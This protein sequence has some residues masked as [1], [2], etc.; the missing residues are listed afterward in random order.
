MRSV[1]KRSSVQMFG[2][3]SV[4]ELAGGAGLGCRIVVLSALVA[5]PV[6]PCMPAPIAGAGGP[7]HPNA[8]TPERLNAAPP[9]VLKSVV[10]NGLRLL[11]KP[12]PSSDIVAI[13]CL[14]RVGVRDEPEENAGIAALLGEAMIRGTERHHPDQM[15][16]AVGAVGGTLEVTPGFDFTEL[17]LATTRDR[18]PQALQLLAEVLGSASLEPAAIDAARTALK[19]RIAELDD[20][21]TASSYQEL[22]LQL[23]PAAP[24]GRPVNGYPASLDRIG[25]QQLDTFY[26]DHYVQNNIVI[27]VVGNIDANAAVEQTRKAFDR[28]EFR[29]QPPIPPI[30]ETF[31]GRPRVSMRQRP[32]PAAQVMLGALAPPTSAASYPTWMVLDAI[33]GGGKRARLFTNLREK[34][35]IG[36][37]LGSFFQPL[38]D[39]SHLVAYVVTAPYRADPRTQAPELALDVVRTQMLEQFQSLADQGPTAAELQRAK[40]YVIGNFARKHERNRDQAHWLVWMEAVGLGFG[41]D[42]DLPGKI[43]AITKEQVQQASKDCLKNHALVVTVP[44]TE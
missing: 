26:H 24:Y 5:L 6:T 43:A 4:R 18:F 38:L 10:P 35:G 19:Q 25:R 16:A 27:A 22:L 30:P 32:A 31:L 23:Y 34:H 28:L 9:D 12:N 2:R 42:R 8:R 11:A 15:A 1:L 29:S 44:T 37:V 20:D 14:V 7:A 39:R 41:F 36:Y 33:I 17:T 13:D 21:L 40:S 3:S